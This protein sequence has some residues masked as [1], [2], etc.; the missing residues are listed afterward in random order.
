MN[1]LFQGKYHRNPLKHNSNREDYKTTV[2]QVDQAALKFKDRIQL[3]LPPEVSLGYFPDNK[4]NAIELF[5]NNKALDF[6]DSSG[7]LNNRI[8]RNSNETIEKW[9]NR[10]IDS[11]KKAYIY[12]IT[13]SLE[14]PKLLEI[15]FQKVELVTE[16]DRKRLSGQI[17]S[18]ANV[19]KSLANELGTL[20]TEQVLE[21]LKDMASEFEKALGKDLAIYVCG[22]FNSPGISVIVIK[23]NPDGTTQPYQ[24]LRPFNDSLISQSKTPILPGFLSA[25]PLKKT[26]SMETFLKRV[27]V[28]IQ[29]LKQQAEDL[30]YYETF[31]D[32]VKK[33]GF[34]NLTLN[35]M[36]RLHALGWQG[37]QPDMKTVKEYSGF[38]HQL[39][40]NIHLSYS[41]SENEESIAISYQ[42]NGKLVSVLG[43]MASQNNGMFKVTRTKKQTPDQFMKVVFEKVKEL[44]AERQR[45]EN[46]LKASKP[47]EAFSF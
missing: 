1:V 9:V 30:V 26:E 38:V 19:S 14:T 4:I 45:I 20:K 44:L 33:N 10:A 34:N 42:E 23:K 13:Q 41:G 43:N 36:P 28:H 27:L 11:A 6:R 39:D 47:D 35:A 22:L 32:E 46:L 2:L 3:A 8:F 5:L 7:Y 12:H 16:T 24:P 37:I 40:P 18:W 25:I 17:T 31:L 21:K 15:D 29:Y